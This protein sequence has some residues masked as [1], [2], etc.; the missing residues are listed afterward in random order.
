MPNWIHDSVQSK[1]TIADIAFMIEFCN[2]LVSAD[3]LG[4]ILILVIE[5]LT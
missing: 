1:H 3:D 4:P 2:P 5:L